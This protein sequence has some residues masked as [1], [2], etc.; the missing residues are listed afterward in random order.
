[1]SESFTAIEYAVLVHLKAEGRC[2]VPAIAADLL[3]RPSE[4]ETTVSA[5]VARNAVK[6]E[7]DFYLPGNVCLEA[8]LPQEK[9]DTS[10]TFKMVRPA[11]LAAPVP[12]AVM[13]EVANV[14]RQARDRARR[15]KA[16]GI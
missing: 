14:F 10:G 1:M 3:L 6:K 11:P 16:G 7:G 5:L 12:A 9:R 13:P 2:T 15:E 4:V 8:P